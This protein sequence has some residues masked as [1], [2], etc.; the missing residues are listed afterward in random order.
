MPKSLKILV[1]AENLDVNASSAAKGRLSLIRNLVKCVTIIKVLHYSRQEILIEGCESISI[2]ER[3]SWFYYLGKFVILLQRFIPVKLNEYVEKKRGFSFTH[4]A[5]A[6]SMKAAVQK[7][8]CKQYDYI[9]TL[10]LASSFRTHRT[11]LDLPDWHSKWLAYVHDPYPMHSYPRPYDWVEPGHQYKRDFFK[12]ISQ[13]AYR[14]IYPSQLLAEWMESY[15]HEAQNKS[16]IIPHLIDDSLVF[17]A[18]FPTYFEGK[19]FNI[20]HSGLLMSARDPR[21]LIQAF[22]EFLNEYPLAM[23]DARLVFV[24]IESVFH[25]EMYEIQKE[26]SQLVISDGYEE[27]HITHA[28]QQKAAVN[29][30]LEAKGPLSPFLPGKFPHSVAANKPILLLG[31]HYSESRRILGEDYPYYSEIHN[32]QLIKSHLKDLYNYWKNDTDRSKLNRPDV[33]EYLSVTTLKRALTQL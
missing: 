20:L 17:K 27:F 21:S 2:K 15:Y 16:V 26:Y 13:N 3:K 6:L 1:L 14:I 19:C 10:S 23:E 9:L 33:A 12:S 24:G 7:E 5:D 11:L 28:M 25:K 31:P 29:V 32:I 22:I 8:D 4:T 18:S 30:I